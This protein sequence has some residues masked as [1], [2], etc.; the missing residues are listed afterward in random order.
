MA[1][2]DALVGDGK[3]AAFA[4]MAA[5]L[6]ARRIGRPEEVAHAA[7]FLMESAFTTGTVLHVDGGHRLV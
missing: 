2:W 5:R 3:A 4:A 6:P 7:P 1:G